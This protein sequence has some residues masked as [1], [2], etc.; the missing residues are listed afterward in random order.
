MTP[1]QL[2]VSARAAKTP[3]QRVVEVEQ[4][5]AVA[6]D[7]IA[8]LRAQVNELRREASRWREMRGSSFGGIPMAQL[9]VDLWLWE[10][11]LNENPALQGIV[12]IG[13]WQGG[14]S[15][16]LYAQAQARGIGFRTFD[17]I[18]PARTAPQ[19]RKVDVFAEPEQVAE[20]I[21]AFGEPV[22]V[23]CD[24]GNKPRELR[25]FA[26]MLK[27]P[28][29]LI[30]VHDWGTEM[31]PTEVPDGLVEAYGDRCDAD[32]SITRWFRTS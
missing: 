4:Q 1:E 7:R 5:L 29:S 23:F 13:T 21:R 30:A 26:P 12:E 20:E 2:P 31:Q 25:T 19:W 8:G 11:V 15:W 3:A 6:D 10:A 14:L 16:W 17:T 18:Q 9:P 22:V 27:D 28:R 24:G 32:G